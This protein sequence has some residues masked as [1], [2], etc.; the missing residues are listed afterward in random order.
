[1]DSV[2]D[3]G[4]M[5]KEPTLR[6]ITIGSESQAQVE[7]ASVPVL[8]PDVELSVVATLHNGD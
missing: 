5:S 1:M 6:P 7:F 3:N 2:Y 8:Q 4:A